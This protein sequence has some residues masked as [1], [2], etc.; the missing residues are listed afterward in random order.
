MGDGAIALIVC[1]H[2]DD[3]AIT[4]KDKRTFNFFN[5][6]LHE[7]FPVN[8]MSD[9]YCYLGCAFEREKTDD[10]VKMT[11]TSFVDSLVDRFDKHYDA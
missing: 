8:D 3:L 7:R 10:V 2:V 6:Q 9:L 11:L 1:V 4:A 5:T